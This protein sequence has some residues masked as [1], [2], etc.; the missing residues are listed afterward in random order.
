MSSHRNPDVWNDN[1]RFMM[2]SIALGYPEEPNAITRR[3]YYEFFN[4][5]PIFI[6]DSRLSNGFVDFLNNL[7]ISNYLHSRDAL[8]QWVHLRNNHENLLLG[9]PKTSPQQ[10]MH[11]H[12]AKY[13][14]ISPN[15]VSHVS[16]LL[17]I[18][19][20]AAAIVFLSK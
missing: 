6:P 5:L 8:V 12:F 18:G 10:T 7:P 14:T 11:Q 15:H 16:K 2:M 20:V 3:K 1:L 9:R 4:N 13:E 19:C 17:G